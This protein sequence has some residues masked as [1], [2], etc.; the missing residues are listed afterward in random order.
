ML[1]LEN[2]KLALAAI[3][4]NKMRSFLTM[5]GI[6]IGVGAVIAIVSIG[7]G[8][9][10]L[11]DDLF[12]SYGKNK[13][14]I[15]LMGDP[16]GGVVTQEDFFTE[17]DLDMLK[18]RFPDALAYGALSQFQSS[19]VQIGKV[20]G[21]LQ[22]FGAGGG[23]Q[24]FRAMEMIRGRMISEED[25]R[26]ARDLIVIPQEAAQRFF[27]AG[28][29]LGK[30]IPVTINQEI[31]EFAVLG[32]YRREKSIFDSLAAG[33]SFETYVPYTALSTQSVEMDLHIAEGYAVGTTLNSMTDYLSRLKRKPEGYYIGT[34]VEAEQTMI[35]GVLGSLSTAIGAIAAIS[36]LVGGVGIMNIMLVSVTERTRE[37]GIRKSLGAKTG[38][39]LLQFLVEAM[40]LS[41]I[42]GLIG[43]GIG[44]GA[45]SV[46]LSF[47]GASVQVDP[48]V[49]LTAVGFS[50]GVGMFF[51]LYPARKAAKLD[52][53]EALRYE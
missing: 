47:A 37:I 22:M 34:S 1:L 14:Y 33:D 28:D 18:E 51:G 10:S 7:N 20:K 5:L 16:D 38:D 40:I 2:I 21:R 12:A 17:A 53:I 27:G 24:R 50:A 26:H 48:R 8:A 41:A 30:L 3:R 9:K 23:Y 13:A 19:N 35:D 11:T 6:I 4:G 42:G 46:G 36:L 43:T 49:V 52:P 39:I 45:A 32:V 25:V 29:A 15:Y 31:R 44:I